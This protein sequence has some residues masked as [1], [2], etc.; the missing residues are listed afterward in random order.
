MNSV[1]IRTVEHT[2]RIIEAMAEADRD[3]SVA[4]L[5]RRIA[6]KR[7]TV[8]RIVQDL[9]EAGYLQRTGYRTVGPG[10]GLVYLG[11]LVT[12]QKYFTPQ[13][14]NELI[15]AEKTLGVKCALGSIVR[16]RMVYLFRTADI[17]AI[18]TGEHW[19]IHGSNIALCIL[20][21]SRGSGKALDILRES[22]REAGYPAEEEARWI[23]DLEKRVSMFVE[24]GY[25]LYSDKRGSNISFPLRSRGITLGLAFY[26]LP[27]SSPRM[28]YLITQCSTLRN[29]LADALAK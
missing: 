4:E 19:P 15:Q 24:L 28:G 23:S 12:S 18:E 8:W 2:L 21:D 11:R 3:M 25:A 14:R 7:L 27:L 26:D 5:S 22:V 20:V 16:N 29:R 10:F 6:V 13:I 9:C 1:K 17:G